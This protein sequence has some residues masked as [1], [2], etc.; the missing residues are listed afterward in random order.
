MGYLFFEQL[1][2]SFC[3]TNFKDH[4]TIFKDS[5]WQIKKLPILFIE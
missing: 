4:Y 3:E 5:N 2:E 1:S